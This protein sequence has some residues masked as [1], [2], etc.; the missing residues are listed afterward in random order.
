MDRDHPDYI[1]GIYSDY[2]DEARQFTPVPG[3]PVPLPFP[4]PAPGPHGPI[5]GPLPIDPRIPDLPVGPLRFCGPISGRYRFARPV[6]SPTVSAAGPGPIVAPISRTS[7][8]V[9]VDVDRY[10][11]QNRISIEASRSFPAHRAHAIAAVRSD[12]CGALYQR[13]VEAHIN[14]REGI[15]ALIP[16]DRVIFEAKRSSRPFA[17]G[18]YQLTLVETNG[19]TR[20]YPLEFL[21][22]YFDDFEFEVDCVSNATPVVLAYNTGSHPN[23]PSTLPAEVID[24]GIVFR[25]AGFQATMSPNASVIPT[26]G[27]GSNGTW[28]DAEMHN[29]MAT[30]WSRF[31]DNPRWAMWVLFAAQHDM[32]FNLGGVMFDDIGPNHRQGTAIFTN[33]FIVNAPAGD[34]VPDAWRERNMFWTAVHE[35]GHAFNLAHSWQKSLGTPWMPLTDDAEARSFMNYPNNVTGGQQSFFSDFAF[36]FSNRELLFMRHA[37]RRFVQMGNENWFENH[38]F[39]RVPEMD[40]LG[41]ALH[42]RANRASNTFDFMEPVKLELKLENRS[43][44]TVIVDHDIVADGGHLELLVKRDGGATKRWRPFVTYCREKQ[45]MLLKP[46]ES[47]YASHFV[48]ASGGGWLIDE[49][50]F[51]FIQAAIE[52][53]G[54]VVVSNPLRIF[55]GTPDTKSEE[56]LAPDYFTEEVARVLAFN[57]APQLTNANAVLE[58]VLV[59]APESA[60]ATHAIVALSDPLKRDFKML[61]I[62]VAGDMTIRAQ[63][64]DVAGAASREIPA[65]VER[66]DAAAE[67]M[68]H[69]DYRNTVEGLTTALVESGDKKKAK[70]VQKSLIDT[71]KSRAVLPAVIAASERKLEGI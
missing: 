53:N 17:Y 20:T 11:P 60:A 1:D 24:F 5:P 47:I 45:N 15:D 62:A 41:M 42:L 67:T 6:L 34:P 44:G 28:S 52:L 35:M 36:R 46:G 50:G 66:A 40:L 57:G 54:V 59:Q 43:Q 13:R 4:G 39:E 69:I 14:F 29:A 71:L 12:V 31:S 3:E 33:S 30:Y 7:F 48:A 21:S 10:Y 38:A 27:A 19:T 56:K 61:E 37:P 49:P 65:L 16:G 63:S 68:G 51:Y 2:G 18:S 64:A 58:E 23:R 26:S 25:R 55:V 70:R 32:G 22:P 8:I 9:R